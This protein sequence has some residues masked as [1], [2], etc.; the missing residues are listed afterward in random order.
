MFL[1]EIFTLINNER[2]K[3]NLICNEKINDIDLKLKFSNIIKIKP[4]CW[5]VQYKQIVKSFLNLVLKSTGEI[6][7]IA[8]GAFSEILI[9]Y[10]WQ[11][12]KQNIYIDI[13]ALFDPFFIGK[14]RS[15]H[16]RVD[17]EKVYRER[18]KI[19]GERKQLI[20]KEEGNNQ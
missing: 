3:F 9:F 14:T 5:R 4:D 6:F 8:A 19:F 16:R 1:D 17:V 15:Y 18:Q 7:L 20:K 12:N 11:L 13:G 2:F 10:A